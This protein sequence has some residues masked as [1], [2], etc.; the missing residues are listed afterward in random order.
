MERLWQ[1]YPKAPADHFAR[2][3]HLDRLVVQVLYNRGL[4]EPDEIEAFLKC[5]VEDDDPFRLR[6]MDAA[7][8][9][10][11][12][13]IERGERI[14]VYGDFD[15]DGVTSTA[16]VVEVLHTLGAEVAPFIPSRVDEGYGLNSAAIK[17]I[18]AKGVSLVVTV[19]CGIRA[20]AEIE[21]AN[22]LGIDVIVTDHHTPAEEPPPALAVINPKQAGDTYGFRGFAGVGLGYKLAQALIRANQRSTAGRPRAEIDPD[23]L[24]DL[25]T[26]GTVA[27]MAPLT[28]ENRAL[29]S[30]GLPRLKRPSRPGV[31]LLLETA[32][33]QPD[34]VN[35]ET[36]S[37]ILG[38]RINAAGRLAHARTAYQLLF[39]REE[40]RALERARQLEE[41]NRRRQELTQQAV[42][43]ARAQII[44]PTAPLLMVQDGNY[45]EGIVGLV[46]GRLMEEF[47]RPAVVVHQGEIR[48]EWRGSARSIPGFDITRA[49]DQC[50]DLL[51]KHGGHSAAAGFTVKAHH[52]QALEDRLTALA[53]EALDGQDLRPTLMIDAAIKLEHIQDRHVTALESLAPFGEQNHEPLFRADGLT[54]RSAQSVGRE[55]K[56]LQL[57]L[58]DRRGQLWR[59]IAFRQGGRLAEV[60]ASRMIDVVFHLRREQ[61]QGIPRLRLVIK[62]FRA[63]R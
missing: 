24:L 31:R 46:A 38:P 61:W 5:R 43:E 1:V 4:R 21:Y 41:Y 47:Y 22:H 45:P 13:A 30:Q 37:F 52:L 26:L 8:R 12:R 48:D 29:V 39:T 20:H 17:R 19:D 32:R 10:I 33:V 57:M 35:T 42:E 49:L 40:G 11:R 58:A 63:S 2:L 59:A 3:N 44:D 60:Q 6:G 50:A 23:D 54:V 27:D 18:A 53:A 55:G 51:V 7:V 16:L 9:R 14:A 25:V 28:G 62:D 15:A 34:G 56:H 36:I